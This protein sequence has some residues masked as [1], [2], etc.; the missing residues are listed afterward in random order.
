VSPVDKW[1]PSPFTGFQPLEAKINDVNAQSAPTQ[2]QTQ[3]PRAQRAD[4][5]RNVELLLEAARIAIARDGPDASLD[6]I[7]RDAG[8]GSG[9]LYRHFPTRVALLEAVYRDEVQRLCAEGDRL[10]DSDAD[11]G[12]ALSEWLRAYVTFGAMKRG[13]MG[14]LT[15]TLGQDSGLFAT[16]KTMVMTT[17]GRLVERAQESGAIREDVELTDVLTLASAIAHAG[18]LTR[19]G[20]GLS[21][22]LLAVAIDG[23]R[24]PGS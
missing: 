22:R 24:R 8:V 12:D 16:C 20:S 21:E 14:P 9:T 6:D 17:G 15:T 1:G 11:P 10:L 3:P 23:L 5:K 4:A 13:L 19:E 2:Q 18:E 7:A